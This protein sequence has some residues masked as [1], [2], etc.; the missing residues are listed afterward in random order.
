MRGAYSRIVEPLK[1]YRIMGMKNFLFKVTLIS[2]FAFVVNGIGHN[3]D[4]A[5]MQACEYLAA[6]GDYPE[7]DIEDVELVK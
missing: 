2:G 6:S 1:T 7:D 3:A 5:L 4:Q